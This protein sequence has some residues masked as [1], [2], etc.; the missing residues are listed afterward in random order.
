MDLLKM[1]LAVRTWFSIKKI[2]EKKAWQNSNFEGFK[3]E[4]A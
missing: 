4:S 3:L 2:D 1:L